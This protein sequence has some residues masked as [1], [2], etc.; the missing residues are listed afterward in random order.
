MWKDWFV[1]GV[2][3]CVSRV[4]GLGGA[5]VVF[6]C[7]NAVGGGPLRERMGLVVAPCVCEWV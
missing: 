6:L 1:C 7:E 5:L 4:G 3:L 2:P